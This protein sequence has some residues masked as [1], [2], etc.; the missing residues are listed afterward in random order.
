MGVGSSAAQAG[1][2]QLA[3]RGAPWFGVGALEG[4]FAVRVE[5]RP[6]APR[7]APMELVGAGGAAVAPFDFATQVL[8][9]AVWAPVF[10]RGPT[11]RSKLKFRLKVGEEG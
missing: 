8:R 1:E 10:F 9:G 11:R 7:G 6:L 3:L 4:H 2:S 5:E